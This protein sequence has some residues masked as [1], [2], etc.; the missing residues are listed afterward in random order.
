MPY[1]LDGNNLVGRERRTSRPSA[2]DRA[3][4]VSEIA[5]RLR[6]TR[7]TATIFF[8]G[9]S[10]AGT[11]TLGRLRVRGSEGRSADDAIV[12]EILRSRSPAEFI[13]VTADRD[14]G[15]R[16]REAGAKTCPPGDFFA[17][18]G[19]GPGDVRPEKPAPVDVEDWMRY[20]EDERNRE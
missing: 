11:G 15:R 9:P 17:R 5:E 2:E 4:L 3:A 1:L 6:R 19:R 13:V 7:A 8:D 16:C 14:L 10:G 12:S 20:F 18:F